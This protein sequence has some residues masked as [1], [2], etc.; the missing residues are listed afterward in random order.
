MRRDIRFW[1]GTCA[2]CVA[3]SE[4]IYIPWEKDRIVRARASLCVGPI[5][6]CVLDDISEPAARP[7]LYIG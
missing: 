1:M 3:A 5:C 6:V 2:V 7:R 4:D